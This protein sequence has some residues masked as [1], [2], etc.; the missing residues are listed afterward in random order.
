MKE[1][2]VTKIDDVYI[3]RTIEDKQT[4]GFASVEAAIEFV[5]SYLAS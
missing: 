1:V 3:V 4:K 2:V 5:K